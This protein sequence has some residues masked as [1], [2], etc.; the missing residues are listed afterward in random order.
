MSKIND[1]ASNVIY[2][3][4]QGMKNFD[5]PNGLYTLEQSTV[6]LGF[7]ECV[8]PSFQE[9]LNDAIIKNELDFTSFVRESMV[10]ELS[11]GSYF[12]YQPLLFYLSSVPYWF[13]GYEESIPFIKGAF[14]EAND[15]YKEVQDESR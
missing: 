6:D 3:M 2:M 15:K 1:M 9:S 4:L 8:L 5:H 13:D 11:Q 12:E 10:Y 7:G 14:I